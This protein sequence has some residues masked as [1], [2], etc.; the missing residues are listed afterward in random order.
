MYSKGAQQA[1]Q[2]LGLEKTAAVPQLL[3]LLGKHWRQLVGRS[4]TGWLRTKPTLEALIRGKTRATKA[5]PQVTRQDVLKRWGKGFKELMIG[6]P[7]AAAKELGEGKFF[8]RGGMFWES[9]KPKGL[10]DAALIYGFPAYEMY[11]MSKSPQGLRG[12]NIGE[13]LGGTALGWGMWK[14]FGL[15][16][17]IPAGIAGAYLGRGLGKALELP[18]KK[19]S[20]YQYGFQQP[21]SYYTGS[22]NMPLTF[23][24]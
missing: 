22:T 10:L 23:R 1:L 16:G 12:R 20:M 4:G 6:Q 18:E 2:D 17:S 21:Q 11:G 9:L 19:P 8:R 13:I 3:K 14:P 5:A 7:R 15:L 24:S